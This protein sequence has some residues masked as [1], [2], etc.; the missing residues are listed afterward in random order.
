MIEISRTGAGVRRAAL[1]AALAAA[2]A[3]A[4]DDPGHPLA[5]PL[6]TQLGLAS[7]SLPGHE[8]MGMASLSLLF[9]PA[10]GWWVGPSVHGAARGERGGLFVAGVEGRRRWTFGDTRLAAGFFAG[11]GGGASAPV[12]DGLMLRPSSAFR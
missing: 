12:G 3:V 7:I 6:S 8:H 10:P 4:A 1:W 11:G 5:L 2:P 9:E